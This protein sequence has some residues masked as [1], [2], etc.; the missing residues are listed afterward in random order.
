MRKL[1]YLL[2]AWAVRALLALFR[3]L[4]L[5][6]AS[7]FGGWIARRIGPFTKA[8]RTMQNNLRRTFPEWS[9][10]K[11][12]DLA[13]N[14]WDN[15]GRTAAEFAF[16]NDPV[17]FER[18]QVTGLEALDTLKTQGNGSIFVSAHYGNWELA[19]KIASDRGLQL[20][21]IYRKANNPYVEKIITRTRGHLY[22]ELTPKGASGARALTE[23][24][25]KGLSIGMLVDQKM[26]DGIPVPF[27]GHDAMTA[28][29]TASLAL[30]YGAPIIP[31]RVIRTQGA[32][33]KAIIEPPLV[34]EKTGDRQQDM[35][36]IM[37]LINQ[38]LERWIRE[39]PE[40][41]FWVHN[42]WPKDA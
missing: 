35:R 21:L 17:M 8:H 25:K 34:Y 41:W 42:R 13:A 3:L 31:A 37:T 19:P 36:H 23:Q 24:L 14:V 7:A 26:N 5:D 15:L 2:E 9:E 16:L 28:P 10:T 12:R 22:D 30:K 20:S 11:R 6:R 1:R 29:A 40:Q 32:H 27:F 38:T 18:V 4:G 39:H 33:F